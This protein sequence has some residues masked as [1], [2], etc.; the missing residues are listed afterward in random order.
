MKENVLLKGISAIASFMYDVADEI[1]ADYSLDEKWRTASKIK[2]AANN[3]YFYT[4]QVVGA[5]EGKALKHECIY[6]RKD[7]KALKA[8]YIFAAK[9]GMTKLDP[10]MILKIDSLVVGLDK[11]YDTSEEELVRREKE[12][13]KPWLEKYRIWQEITKQ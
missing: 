11:A 10:E 9:Q 6:A 4:A 13:L 5:G 3:S 2:D 1:E 12:E 8:M 7:L